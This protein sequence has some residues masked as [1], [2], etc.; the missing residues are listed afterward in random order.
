MAEAILKENE[1]YVGKDVTEKAIEKIKKTEEGGKK[2]EQKTKK[3]TRRT[4]KTE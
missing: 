2:D 3:R 4:S 1:K